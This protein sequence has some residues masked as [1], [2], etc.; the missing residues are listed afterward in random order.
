MMVDM[1]YTERAQVMMKA[2][3]LYEMAIAGDPERMVDE[4]LTD[5]HG[6]VL[7]TRDLDERYVS[8][9]FED[10]EAP[11]AC[12]DTGERAVICGNVRIPLPEW[13]CGRIDDRVEYTLG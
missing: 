8:V 2:R 3:A 4:W 9:R 6:R 13:L 11:V 10:E 5:R 7:V 12:L 1:G